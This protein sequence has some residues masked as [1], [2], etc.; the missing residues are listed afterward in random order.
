MRPLTQVQVNGQGL[1]IPFP[2][3]M[4]LIILTAN[5]SNILI[6]NGSQLQV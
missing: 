2:G 6:R 4:M 5:I 3:I 1:A